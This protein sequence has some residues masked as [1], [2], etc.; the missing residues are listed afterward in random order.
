MSG[1]KAEGRQFDPALTTSLTSI[2][3]DFAGSS[4]SGRPEMQADG[5]GASPVAAHRARGKL[6]VQRCARCDALSRERSRDE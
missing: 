2:D 4:S 1:L 3:S 6:G 5:S